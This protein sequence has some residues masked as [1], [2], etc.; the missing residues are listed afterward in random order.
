MPDFR[1]GWVWL[2]GAGPGDPGHL[3]L[4]A[5]HALA[6]ADLVFHDALVDERVLSFANPDAEIRFAGKRAGRRSP[7]QTEITADLIAAA[8]RGLRVLRLKGGDPFVFGRGAEEALMLAAAGVPF[9][10]VP[11]IS[12]GIGA[13]A[14]AGIP[15]THR[16]LNQSVAFVTGTDAEG[17]MSKAVDWAG[18]AR[19]VPMIV[20]YMGLKHR[21]AIAG[22]LL[23]AGR[24]P[25]EPAA[26]VSRAATPEQAVLDLTLQDLAGPLTPEPVAPA[27][28]V[29]GETV[30]LRRELG[31]PHCEV[32]S[33]S[34]P[35]WPQYSM[36]NS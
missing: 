6:Q 5:V 32:L 14:A 9:H 11:G 31:A 19:S 13:L 30:A 10:V 23:A 17:E 2:V 1:P 24:S 29:I 8:G 15:L 3:T 16:D 20:V 7:R 35:R 33:T 22:Q 25:L 28:L 26:I 4:A 34:K 18:L 21:R 27:M 36:I 12:A